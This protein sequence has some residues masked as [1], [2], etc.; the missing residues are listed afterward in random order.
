MVLRPR[1]VRLV[2][3][4]IPLILA[5]ALTTS[6]SAAFGHQLA[7]VP[8]GKQILAKEGNGNHQ[9]TLK[10]A[11]AGLSSAG[12]SL[13]SSAGSRA[14]SPHQTAADCSTAVC[15]FSLGVNPGLGAGKPFACPAIQNARATITISNRFR[16]NAQNDVMV[17]HASGLP[18]N[19]GFDLFLIQN[20]PR[21]AG[22]FPGFG[23]GWY[24]SDLQ[25]NSYGSA[26]AVVAG[27]FD[28]ETFIENPANAFS[29]IHT[30]NVGFWFNSPPDEQ[31]VC[32]NAT[33]PA[34]TP[35]NGEQN[36]GLLAMITTGGPLQQ[37]H[38]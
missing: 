16:L 20:S 7:A 23:F 17:V 29:P 8:A 32:G 28:V 37:I 14:A 30:Y 38:S 24:Q 25:S 27:I 11:T 9:L 2:A 35:F 31:R 6:A 4:M 10:Q 22:A 18:P 13:A 1:F 26:T 15:T 12:S 33:A 19:T 3:I 36:A 5:G 21:D 34:A